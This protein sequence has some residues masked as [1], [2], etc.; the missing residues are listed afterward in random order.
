MIL[1]SLQGN[2]SEVEMTKSSGKPDLG[3]SKSKVEGVDK[4]AQKVMTGDMQKG[5]NKM[6]K[7]MK[8]EAKDKN[9]VNEDG[10]GKVDAL[11]VLLLSRMLAACSIPCAVQQTYQTI[12]ISSP[13]ILYVSAPTMRCTQRNF[14]CHAYP[15]HTCLRSWKV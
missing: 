5:G 3:S 13:E 9:I 15:C 11:D 4:T 10:D 2:D 7:S 6:G 1:L 14:I 8:K 12:R